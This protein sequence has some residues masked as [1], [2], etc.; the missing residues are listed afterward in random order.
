MNASTPNYEPAFRR[1]L[2][3][4]ISRIAG[5]PLEGITCESIELQAARRKSG[6]ELKILGH[7]RLQTFAGFPLLVPDVRWLL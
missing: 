7:K 1:S 4:I 6:K 2:G 5:V 3:S